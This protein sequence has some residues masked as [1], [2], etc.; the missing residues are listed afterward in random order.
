MPGHHFQIAIQQELT[1]LPS[2]R[3]FGGY[4]AYVEGWG[5]YAESLGRDLGLYTDP[6]SYFGALSGEIWR[7]IRLVVDTGM[8]AK[9]W[10]RQQALDYLLANSA[11]GATDAAAEIDRYIAMPGQALTYKIGELRI[12][13]LKARAQ[14]ELGARYDV[15]AFHRAI[16]GDGALPLDV[17]DA[18]V[19]RWIATQ[20]AAP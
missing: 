10:S 13:E 16:L 6:Y 15:R 17:L 1:G 4:G 5:L 9:G 19:A 2:F 14:R 7:A 8:H 3:R 18:K 20:K 12:Q 11:V